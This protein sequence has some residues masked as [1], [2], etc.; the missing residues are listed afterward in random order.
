MARIQSFCKGSVMEWSRVFQVLIKK[1][2]T[3]K[4]RH[5][6]RSFPRKKGNFILVG[7]RKENYIFMKF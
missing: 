6:K 1:I 3:I 2:G 7:F 5:N 4:T